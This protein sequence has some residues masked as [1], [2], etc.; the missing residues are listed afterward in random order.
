[1]DWGLTNMTTHMVAPIDVCHAET[2]PARDTHALRRTLVVDVRG[3]AMVGGDHWEL[4]PATGR[5]EPATALLDHVP[6]GGIA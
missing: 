2:G 4:G 1:M 6:S 5:L 3:P